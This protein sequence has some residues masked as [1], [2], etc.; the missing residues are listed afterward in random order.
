MQDVSHGGLPDEM[1]TKFNNVNCSSLGQ[2]GGVAREVVR[3]LIVAGVGSQ[4]EYG[5]WS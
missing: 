5:V 4:M 1:D 2:Q 3:S